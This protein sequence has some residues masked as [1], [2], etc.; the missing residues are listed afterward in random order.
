VCRA[1]VTVAVVLALAVVA[2]A[3]EDGSGGSTIQVFPPPKPKPPAPPPTPPAPPP[4]VNQPP[5]PDGGAPPSQAATPPPTDGGTAPPAKAT[6]P[7]AKATPPPANAPPPDGGM[8]EVKVPAGTSI[9]EVKP[10][11]AI[12]DTRAG[13]GQVITEIKIVDNTKTDRNTVEYLAHVRVGEILTPELVEQVRQNLLSV[14]LFKDVGIS[15]EPASGAGVRLVISAKDKLSWIVAPIFQYTSGSSP[16]YGGGIAYANSNAFGANKKFLAFADYTTTEKMLLLVWLD[17]QIR[18]TPFYYRVDGIVRG[19]L[20]REYAAGYTNS[21]RIERETHLD[22]FG[23][24]ALL[25]VNFAR[26]WHLDL[27]L[28]IFYDYVHDPVCYNTTNKDQSG[29]PDVVADQGGSCVQPSPSSWDNTWTVDFGYDGRSKVFGVLHGLKVHFAYQYGPTWM[30]DA[31]T[32]HLFTLDGMYAWRFFKEHNLLL[33][34]G[35]DVFLDPP[36][37]QEVETGGINMRGFLFRQYRG[38]TDVRLTL[39]YILPLFELRGLA[40]RLAAFYDTNLTWFRSLPPQTTPTSRFVVRDNGYR[41]FLPD[42]PSGVV[43]DSW[44][45]GVGLGLRFFLKGVVLPL[46]GLDV[47]YGFESTD[48]QVYLSLGST[49]D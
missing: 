3:Q 1:F 24:A 49:I 22:T 25:G 4:S 11:G 8:T 35:A 26:K 14:G 27:R 41:A 48:V 9:N 6:P 23:A 31:T 33:K 34:L 32:Y 40:T 2:A 15:W 36:L 10:P 18:N 46:I 21:P 38:D 30:G 29:T 17:P 20:V 44:H 42:T 5:P 12:T 16:N 37:K 19:D 13:M 43:R 45:N 7:P 39:E 47:A 28:K